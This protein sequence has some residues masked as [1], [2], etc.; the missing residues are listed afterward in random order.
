MD[1]T[2]LD[3]AIADGHA[4]ITHQG[5][6]QKIHYTAE[7]FTGN[8]L[9]PEEKI[10]AEFWAELIYR[11]EYEPERIGIEVTVPDRTPSDRADLIVFTDDEK[12]RP[13]IVVECKPDGI[14]GLRKR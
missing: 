3:R 14:P 6:T 9:H 2:Y 4:E 10:R 13:Y 7:D 11:Y 12:K 8:H 5:N 1:T